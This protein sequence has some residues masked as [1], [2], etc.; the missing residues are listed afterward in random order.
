MASDRVNS[1]TPVGIAEYNSSGFYNAPAGVNRIFVSTIGA[2][3]GPGGLTVNGADT[4]GQGGAAI[5]GGAAYSI[6]PGVTYT[7]T[8][9]AV[10][11]RGASGTNIT[12]RYGIEGTNNG[13]TG[14]TGGSTTFDSTITANGG[15]G[16]SGSGNAIATGTAGTMSFGQTTL[17]PVYPA[18]AVVRTVNTSTGATQGLRAGK[19]I[20]FPLT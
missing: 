15:T 11:A 17:P 1:K 13:G 19:V 5:S 3:G 14:S 6:S 8:I 4:S 9:G 7:V 2:S 20:I 12:G 10:G 18:G 16:G